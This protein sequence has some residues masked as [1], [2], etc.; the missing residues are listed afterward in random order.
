[1]AVRSAID[2]A[3]NEKYEEGSVPHGK[4]CYLEI[5]ANRAEDAASFYSRIFDWKVGSAATA[6]WRSMTPGA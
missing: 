1:M 6:N 4:I 3:P 2:P 5:P